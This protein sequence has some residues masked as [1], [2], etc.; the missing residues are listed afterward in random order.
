V[1]INDAMAEVCTVLR[2]VAATQ[3]MPF[4][5]QLGAESIHEKTPGELVTSADRAAEQ[6]LAAALARIAPA[7][8]FIGEEAC[9]ADPLLRTR[10][11]DD[12]VWLVDPIDGTAN[13]AAGRAPFALMVALLRRGVTEA[14]WVFEPLADAMT[15]A[16]RGAGAWQ[17]GR[18]LAGP[19]D[20]PDD[21][22]LTGIVSAAF[23]PAGKKGVGAALT[24]AVGTILPT[25]RCA[26]HEYPLVAAGQRDFALYWR[27]LPWDH[28]PG[29]LLVREAGGVVVHLDGSAFDPTIER[30]GVIVARNERIAQRVLA[31]IKE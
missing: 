13:Y 8:V 20:L 4:L 16:R 12:L 30:T 18:R 27:T 26:G 10:L 3:V 29:A 23:V 21:A 1:R 28:V 11:A 31:I 6:A 19:A 5:G 24:S 22:A 25:A 7:A 15:W 9:A 14:A 2:T 17:N